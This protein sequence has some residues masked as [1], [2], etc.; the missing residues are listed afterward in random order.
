MKK[1]ITLS[2]IAEEISEIIQMSSSKG[3]IKSG[4]INLLDFDAT[5]KYQ[6]DFIA[7]KT[8][9][10]IIIMVNEMDIWIDI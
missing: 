2:A 4:H 6:K 8:H 3:I 1:F 5:M 7:A 10:I 9:F